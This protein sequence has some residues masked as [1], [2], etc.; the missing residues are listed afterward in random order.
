MNVRLPVGALFHIPEA[1]ER[2][3]YSPQESVVNQG[4]EDKLPKRRIIYLPKATEKYDC[5]T[6][7]G[8]GPYRDFEFGTDNML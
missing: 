2:D 4:D 6:F 7:E 1:S 8:T 5:S 3:E